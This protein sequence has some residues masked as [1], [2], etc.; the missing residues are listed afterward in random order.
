MNSSLSEKMFMYLL[1]RICFALLQE[2][3]TGPH[4]TGQFS[5]NISSPFSEYGGEES[6][7]ATVSEGFWGSRFYLIICLFIKFLYHHF[8]YVIVSSLHQ[9]INQYKHMTKSR[10][11]N[12]KN[13]VNI[14]ELKVKIKV[15]KIIWIIF[16]QYSD[17]SMGW[18]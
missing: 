5:S 8:T 10:D 7:C 6:G 17:L 3:I 4:G 11:K 1:K 14:Y 15:E 16:S 13:K 9:Y 12:I 2:S 18:K